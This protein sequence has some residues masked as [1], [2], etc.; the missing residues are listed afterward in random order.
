MEVSGVITHILEKRSGAKK[1]GAVWESQDVVIKQEGDY[2][3]ALVV[4]CNEKCIQYLQGKQI[5]GQ[6]KFSVNLES[7]EYNGKYYTQVK[8]WRVG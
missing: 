2:G 6:V 1:D 5:G 7:R 8:A 3:K 4:T